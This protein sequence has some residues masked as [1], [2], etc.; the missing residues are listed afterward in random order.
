[1]SYS[2]NDRILALAGIYQACVLVGKIAHHGLADTAAQEIC[3]RSLFITTPKESADVYGGNDMIA[4]NLRLGLDTLTEQF[5][6]TGKRDIELT[7]YVISIL[8]LER[9]LMKKPVMLQALSQG[10]D[11]ASSQAEH[12]S[13]CHENVVANLAD[14]YI[15]TISTLSPRIIVRGEHGHL[16]NPLNASRVRA[17]LLA[18]IRSAILW[19]QCGGR[20]WQLLLQRHSIIT[21]VE[22]WRSGQES[23][24]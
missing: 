16:S 19:R 15:Q 8:A 11:R 12:F 7:R 22:Y 17:L 6:E 24:L 23:R 2:V 13:P 1:M 5:G 9:K 4:G 20:R 10:I 14:L 21:A 18:A 3:I